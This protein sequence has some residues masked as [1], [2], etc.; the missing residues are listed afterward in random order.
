MGTAG[1]PEEPLLKKNLQMSIGLTALCRVSAESK[2]DPRGLWG[3]WHPPDLSP[4]WDRSPCGS[5][6]CVP[7]VLHA[8]AGGPL[9]RA[10]LEASGDFLGFV[11]LLK[12][13]DAIRASSCLVPDKG[14]AGSEPRAEGGGERGREAVICRVCEGGKCVCSASLKLDIANETFSS[15]CRPI[16]PPIC[17][18]NQVFTYKN[19][20]L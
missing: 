5:V 12:T 11:G 16:P 18:S 1:C 9:P 8:S 19:L 15:C 2:P 3:A 7:T 10:V 14:S 20:F 13:C 6:S 17:N 4:Q